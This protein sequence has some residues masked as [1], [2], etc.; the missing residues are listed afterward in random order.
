MPKFPPP[1]PPFNVSFRWSFAGPLAGM[2]CVQWFETS[3][4][5]TWGDNYLCW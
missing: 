4:P 5:D 3:D 2:T 1:P